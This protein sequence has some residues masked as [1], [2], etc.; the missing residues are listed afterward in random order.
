MHN[1]RE[2]RERVAE[3]LL[4][5]VDCRSDES[6]SAELARDVLS[7]AQSLK[8][9][10]SLC[11]WLLA[12]VKSRLRLKITGLVII[13]SYDKDW[14]TLKLDQRILAYRRKGTRKN[15]GLSLSLCDLAREAAC[16][17]D[18]SKR[19]CPCRCHSPLRYLSP[20]LCC[21]RL[22]FAPHERRSAEN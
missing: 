15:S 6:I 3:L 13:R 4:D 12:L 2:T 9:S 14:S 8:L 17:P 20:P 21:C 10:V 5:G 1:C 7:A 16:S 18:F 19:P 22:L 11:A